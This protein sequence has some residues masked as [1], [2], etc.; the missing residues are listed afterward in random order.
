MPD[1]A[2]IAQ[3]SPLLQQ[4]GQTRPDTGELVKAAQS[5]NI[6]ELLQM[7]FGG[8]GVGLPEAMMERHAAEVPAVEGQTGAAPPNLPSDPLSGP[9]MGHL[10]NLYN[11][12]QSNPTHPIFSQ[13]GALTGTEPP[14]TPAPAT[15]AGGL[16][17]AM[18][19]AAPQGLP[20]LRTAADA[21]GPR[22]TEASMMGGMGNG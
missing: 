20:G 7:I 15:T 17:T 11:L 9:F 10:Q 19:S 3:I 6:A 1:P 18:A 13:L 12:F 2:G 5:G 8:R 14:G 22:T 21:V 16:E 4:L